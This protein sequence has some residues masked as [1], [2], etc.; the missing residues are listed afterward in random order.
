[1]AGNC[2]KDLYVSPHTTTIPQPHS[3]LII[4]TPTSGH[5]IGDVVF[6]FKDRK[7]VVVNALEPEPEF[8]GTDPKNAFLMQ[9][10]YKVARI[11]YQQC[12]R[13]DAIKSAKK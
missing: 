10:L 9:R 2:Q 5:K 6:H 8:D 1:M 3:A 11:E 12:R 4:H 7:D 13:I